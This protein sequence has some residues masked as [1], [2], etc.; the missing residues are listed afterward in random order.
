MQEIKSNNY[1]K[2]TPRNYFINIS[3]FQITNIK[4]FHKKATKFKLIYTIFF[5]LPPV[6]VKTKLQNKINFANKF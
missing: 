5:I 6:N 4:T 2:V 3:I 1:A